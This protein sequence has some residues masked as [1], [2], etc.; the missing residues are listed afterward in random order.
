MTMIT[1]SVCLVAF[2]LSLYLAKWFC[3]DD[4]LMTIMTQMMT[5]KTKQNEK[6][7]KKK[8]HMFVCFF[9]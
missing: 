9:V 7:T 6:K 5:K 8:K 4:Y 3:P 1:S 2:P